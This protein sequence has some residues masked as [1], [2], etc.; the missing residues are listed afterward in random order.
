M[1]TDRPDKRIALPGL[2]VLDPTA[3]CAL[4][5]VKSGKEH[6]GDPVG[7]NNGQIINTEDPAE[8]KR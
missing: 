5:A 3:I 7:C 6:F 2:F 8:G 1:F 4:C